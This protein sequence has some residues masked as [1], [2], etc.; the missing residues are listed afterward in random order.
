MDSR[1]SY[2][3]KV[4]PMGEELTLRSGQAPEIF[5][6]EGN[7]Y[8]ARSV[9][10][11]V[12]LVKAKG[13]KERCVICY[14]DKSAKAILDD[15]VV[16]RPQD[17]VSLSFANSTR[18]KEWETILV[19]KGLLFDQKGLVDFLSRR[20]PGEIVGIEVFKAALENF[21]YVT[22]I[23]G[24]FS[25][26]D[27]HNYTFMIK[28]GEAEGSVKLPKII[29]VNMEIFHESGF[30]QVMEVEL[31]FLKPK[32]ENEKPMFMLSCPKIERYKEKALEAEIGRLKADL[33]GY[34]VVAGDF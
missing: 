6:Y 2:E 24:D 7:S 3:M 33:E 16:C 9:D 5:V 32:S 29:E 4:V 1:G 31:E 15:Q 27:S 8:C 25:R 13:V 17:T 21:K 26:V 18:F 23:Q 19:G 22:N 34:L 30:L 14:T 20:E 28:V 12:S 11:F 10:A